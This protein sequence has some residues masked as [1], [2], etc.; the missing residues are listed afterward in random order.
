MK[1]F[2]RLFVLWCIIAF[3][4]FAGLSTLGFI[5]KN[6]I[7]K[8]EDFEL[9]I[10]DAAKEYVSKEG[11]IDFDGDYMDVSVDF[12]LKNGY[13]STKDLVKTCSGKVRIEN[14]KQIKYIPIVK[15]KNYKS[16]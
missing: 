10:I 1:K 4:I 12:L 11:K 8:Y 16:R 3:L 9:V 2:N 13:L 15:C 6:R 5:Y 7:K 14:K